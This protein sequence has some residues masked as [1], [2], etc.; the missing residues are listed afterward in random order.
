MKEPDSASSLPCRYL[1]LQEEDF[2]A[3]WAVGREESRCIAKFE[4]MPDCEDLKKAIAEYRKQILPEAQHT[5]QE[6]KH[7]SL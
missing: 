3:L 2:V 7:Q 1:L 4:K 5:D 6:Q